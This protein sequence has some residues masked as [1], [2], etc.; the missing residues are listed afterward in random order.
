[1]VTSAL[2]KASQEMMPAPRPQTIASWA[3]GRASRGS[4]R[5]EADG[6]AA[7]GHLPT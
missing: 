7:F 2:S 5:R 3:S 6:A 1:M 4:G